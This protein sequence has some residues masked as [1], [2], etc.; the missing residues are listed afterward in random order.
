MRQIHAHPELLTFQKDWA[1]RLNASITCTTMREAWR[2]T[3]SVD[4]AF[5][6]KVDKMGCD[7]MF[8]GRWSDKTSL[9]R[10]HQFFRK[11]QKL[12]CAHQ[13]AVTGSTTVWEVTANKINREVGMTKSTPEPN[14]KVFAMGGHASIH[15]QQDPDA[16]VNTVRLSMPRLGLHGAQARFSQ[17]V[18]RCSRRR[19]TTP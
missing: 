11:G 17:Q 19:P 9:D 1:N 12:H 3:I 5:K 16:I 13:V 7:V 18:C 14:E 10:C 8:E 6:R 15:M 4:R 2:S